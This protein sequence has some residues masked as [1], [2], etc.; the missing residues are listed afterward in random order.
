MAYTY[1]ND[2]NEKKIQKLTDPVQAAAVLQSI[3]TLAG[4]TEPVTGDQVN[5]WL[6]VLAGNEIEARKVG[7]SQCTIE[8]Y[9]GGRRSPDRIF[10]DVADGAVTVVAVG[11]ASH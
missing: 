8:I 1:S 4:Q 10:M 2:V 9:P 11:E 5:Q 6:G 7:G 3:Q